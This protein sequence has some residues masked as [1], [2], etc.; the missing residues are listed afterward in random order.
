M[1]TSTS[2]V[3]RE[4]ETARIGSTWD[5]GSMTISRR[6][7]AALDQY[8]RLT[9]RRMFNIGYR[10][11]K[12]TNWVGVVGVG[13]HC[14]EVIPKI[15]EPDALKARENLLIMIA[16]AGLLP[17]SQ[18]DITKLARAD[19][20]LLAAYMELY[21]D[22]LGEEWRKGPIRHYVREDDNRTCLKGKLLFPIHL[23][24]NVVHRERF[25]TASD[26]FTCDNEVSQLLKAAL[27]RCRTQLFSNRLARKARSLLPDFEEVTDVLCT[28]SIMGRIQVD[29][30][31]KRFEPL[32]NLAKFILGN[33]SPSPGRTGE[34][35]Y[36]LM[37]DMNQVFER[38]IAAEVV[39]A[40][41]GEPYRVR[42]QVK[43]RSLLRRN[44]RRQFALHPDIGVYRDRMNVC[45]VD[46]KWK[47]LDRSRP[48]D[49]VSQA[50]MY[51]MYAY[52][53]EYASPTIILMY[54]RH[55][56]FPE[57]VA[58]YQHNEMEN[59]KRIL[60]RT[61]DVSSPLSNRGVIS[62]L[63]RTLREMVVQQAE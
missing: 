52:G 13:K 41:R 42:P 11:V 25:F 21:I 23:R 20:P 49:N 22:R 8:Q 53:K 32:V 57:E 27:Q 50:D 16:R 48:H 9:G 44:D 1:R 2:L 43:G 35:V 36:S 10:T 51:Q 18:A 54:P 56:G 61:V 14:I 26:E 5:P 31:I 33:V 60:V 47:R 24:I 6:E 7:V 63:R 30:R 29:R 28:D 17:V 37:F 46:T 34:A 12:A 40:L 62:D 59:A 15:D 39:T 38:F 19:K 4:F 58:D 45:L 3:L 55:S